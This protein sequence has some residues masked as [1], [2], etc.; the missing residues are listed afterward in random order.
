MVAVTATSTWTM[1]RNLISV[2]ELPIADA[3]AKFDF[4]RRSGDEWNPCWVQHQQEQRAEVSQQL[5]RPPCVETGGESATWPT[6]KIPST[7]KCGRKHVFINKKR[8]ADVSLSSASIFK[9]INTLCLPPDDLY[10]S[11]VVILISSERDR[12]SRRR[13]KNFAL[14]GCDWCADV[15]SGCSLIDCVVSSYKRDIKDRCFPPK[16]QSERR[17]APY[18]QQVTTVS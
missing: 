18:T 13:V 1:H 5:K 9:H 17:C 4:E 10:A 3:Q 7:Y 15:V 12:R 2:I 11:R 14:T 16:T 6:D 8:K